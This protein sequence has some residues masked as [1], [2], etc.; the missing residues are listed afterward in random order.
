MAF[1]RVKPDKPFNELTLLDVKCTT[2]RCNDNFHCFK[3]SKEMI[4]KYGKDGVCRDCG[5]DV[6]DWDRIQ[7]K[8]I[9]DAGYT[10]DMMKIEL[11]RNICWNMPVD[12]LTIE[13]AR[14]RGKNKLRERAK[15]ILMQKVGKAK[16]FRE[17]YQTA[18]DGKEIINYAQHATA[19]CCRPCMEY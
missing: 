19:T 11:L 9:S 8:D 15:K 3:T 2:T 6:V 12:A 4:E 1:K 14:K 18:K 17:G 7:K 16:N 5:T 13:F 10:F